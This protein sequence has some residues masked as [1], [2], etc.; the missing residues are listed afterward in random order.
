MM[1]R[2]SAPTTSC[3]RSCTMAV[4]LRSE[5]LPVAGSEAALDRLLAA[6]R[7][8][9]GEFPVLLANHLPMVLVAMQRLG[10]SAERLA[11]FFAVYRD[12]NHLAPAPA[13]VAPIERANWSATLG[14]R[15]R[16]TDYRSFFQAEVA[17]LGLR[18]TIAAY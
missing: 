5:A 16:E 12:T 13:P 4:A 7:G 6:G 17:R 15:K 3:R 18:A 10:G 8:F 11:E 1:R 14:D 9:S 2:T